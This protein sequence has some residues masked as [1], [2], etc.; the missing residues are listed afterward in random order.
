M[1]TNPDH[2]FIF[3]SD[4]L[5]TS[6]ARIVRSILDLHPLIDDWS[7]DVDDADHVLRIVSCSMDK[8]KITE[9]ITLCGYNCEELAD[10]I[11]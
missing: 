11:K 1:K 4:I 7:V 6:D 10:E 3:S 2:I 8:K 9:L 5:T